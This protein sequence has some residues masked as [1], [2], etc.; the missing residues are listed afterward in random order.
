M[1]GP[2]LG[3]DGLRRGAPGRGASF[4]PDLVVRDG[5][6][7]RHGDGGPGAVVV[8]AGAAAVQSGVTG[9]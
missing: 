1:R 4:P 9:V 2:K 5:E 3:A 7:R 8:R 6:E